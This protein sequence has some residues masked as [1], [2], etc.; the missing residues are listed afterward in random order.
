MTKRAVCCFAL[1]IAFIPTSGQAPQT[2]PPVK[3]LKPEPAIPARATWNA[4]W[5]SLFGISQEQFH[6]LGY[7]ALSQDQGKTILTWLFTNRH[8]LSCRKSFGY[9]DKEGPKHIY[10]FIEAAN[11]D[12]ATFVGELRSKIGM[13]QD[14][15]LAYS[16]SDADIVVNVL[17]ESL[18]SASGRESGYL[19]AI[20]LLAPCSYSV[21]SGMSAGTSTFRKFLD[22][23]VDTG[24]DEASVLA[25]AA[26]TLDVNDFDPVRTDHSN[27]MKFQ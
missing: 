19:A 18:K 25:R 16:D 4:T 15:K 21:P 6:A 22:S 13:T 23:F 14:V 27:F 7:D 11:T 1:L 5:Q 8:L 12:S 26:S 20:T 10:P 17:A 2:N 9:D 24:P 3:K